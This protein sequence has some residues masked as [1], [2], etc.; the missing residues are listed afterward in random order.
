MAASGWNLEEI[1]RRIASRF[2]PKVSKIVG[3]WR[4][5]QECIAFVWFKYQEYGQ[6]RDPGTLA[7]FKSTIALPTD[8]K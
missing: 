1:E 4:L 8:M 5:V 3:F 2:G 7:E 6:C